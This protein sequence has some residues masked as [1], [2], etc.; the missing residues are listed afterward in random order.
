[1]QP[2]ELTIIDRVAVP[3]IR[4]L[5]DLCQN[6]PAFAY[7]P[8]GGSQLAH[9]H[10]D[11]EG[12]FST[13][14]RLFELLATARDQVADWLNEIHADS[15]E[16]RNDE[17]ADPDE[18]VHVPALDYPIRW[19][20]PLSRAL[21]DAAIALWLQCPHG[22]DTRLARYLAFE[23]AETRRLRRALRSARLSQGLADVRARGIQRLAQ[24]HG[25]RVRPSVPLG[26]ALDHASPWSGVGSRLAGVHGLVTL[27]GEGSTEALHALARLPIEG[28]AGLRDDSDPRS[29]ALAVAL[30]ATSSVLRRAVSLYERSSVGDLPRGTLG[31]S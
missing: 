18:L 9:D 27:V 23:L 25:I 10:D 11:L 20:P 15:E 24:P 6:F 31:V 30:T 1:M 3:R 2:S 8:A 4:D 14:V 5:H 16:A 22:G 28:D 17:V 12:L 26:E 13:P 29:T 19:A 7:P 21:T